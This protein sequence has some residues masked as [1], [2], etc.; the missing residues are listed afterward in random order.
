[1]GAAQAFRPFVDK[2][3]RRDALH[4]AQEKL[5]QESRDACRGLC[6]TW[7]L[8][9]GWY[10][11]AAAEPA[12]NK[13]RHH[14]LLGLPGIKRRF[15]IFHDG[16]QFVARLATTR[17]Q[18]FDASVR[19]AILSLRQCCRCTTALTP[20]VVPMVTRLVDAWLQL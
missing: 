18:I 10:M 13:W 9:D 1:M 12:D 19:G 7:T 8:R 14:R 17:L 4:K 3:A 16:E 15:W 11:T 20:R 6:M 5:L 2:Q